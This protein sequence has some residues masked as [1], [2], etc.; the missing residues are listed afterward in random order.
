MGLF[1]RLKRKPKVADADDRQRLIRTQNERP[2]REF[3]DYVHLQEVLD[4]K[5]EQ[6]QN[7]SQIFQSS[8]PRE[9]ENLH[10]HEHFLLF[11]KGEK[12]S[13]LNLKILS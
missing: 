11:L 5:E 12:C 4:A 6:F 1:N 8:S 3:F 13:C 2:L 9:P 7:S 10:L